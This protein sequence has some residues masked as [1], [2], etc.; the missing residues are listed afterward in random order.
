[1]IPIFKKGDVLDPNN[2]RGISLMNS[3]PK[4]F[5]LLLTRRLYKFNAIK[6][7]IHPKYA[8]FMPKRVAI[9]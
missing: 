4:V 3:I 8:G 1:M 2:Y 7:I 9:E 6:T 5:M